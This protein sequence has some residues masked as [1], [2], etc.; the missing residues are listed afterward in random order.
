M[1]NFEKF[2]SLGK[3]SRNSKQISNNNQSQYSSHTEGDSSYMYTAKAQDASFSSPQSTDF[4]SDAISSGQ[5]GRISA[6]N[7]RRIDRPNENIKLMPFK[8]KDVMQMINNNPAYRDKSPVMI[9]MKEH[10]IDRLIE[11]QR[12]GNLMRLGA[13]P[14]QSLKESIRESP[15]SMSM[16]QSEEEKSSQKSPASYGIISNDEVLRSS[17][18]SAK[19]APQPRKPPLGEAQTQQVF[20]MTGEAV[21]SRGFRVQKSHKRKPRARSRKVTPVRRP[22]SRKRP[23]S[24]VRSRSRRRRSRPTKIVRA[25]SRRRSPVVVKKRRYLP[26]MDYCCNPYPMCD[27]TCT[28]TFPTARS[29]R[30]PPYR[31]PRRRSPRRRSPPAKY[32]QSRAALGN[33]VPSRNRIFLRD[34]SRSE[35]RPVIMNPTYLPNVLGVTHSGM[36]ITCDCNL[37]EEKLQFIQPG[38]CTKRKDIWTNEYAIIPKKQINL[39]DPCEELDPLIYPRADNPCIRDG[40]GNPL[41][42]CIGRPL[43]DPVGK[44]FLS[45][46]AD[47]SVLDTS[48]RGNFYT[49][50][51]PLCVKCPLPTNTCAPDATHNWWMSCGYPVQPDMSPFYRQVLATD[52]F[53]RR[54]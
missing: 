43:R 32:I 31:S 30:S 21:G 7:T 29:Y 28:V 6:H 54:L 13:S 1:E 33:P 36:S 42:D 2:G 3:G 9:N 12:N 4:A 19:Q 20:A 49:G 16:R 8:V 22:R 34:Q 17:R 14:Q 48:V 53:Q 45:F 41:T 47:G 38:I 40:H 10:D 37:C 11:Q 23:R 24:R 52:H 26:A 46:S 50:Q 15:M 35:N 27:N 18:T 25:R 44:K 51:P 5:S 39:I